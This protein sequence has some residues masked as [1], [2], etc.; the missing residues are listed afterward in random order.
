MGAYFCDIIEFWELNLQIVYEVFQKISKC[1]NRKNKRL[2]R[3]YWEIKIKY[4]EEEN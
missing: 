2:E 4:E 1:F 3:K